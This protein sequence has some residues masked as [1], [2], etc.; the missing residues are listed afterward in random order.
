ME[1]R[2]RAGQRGRKGI[3]PVGWNLS[4]VLIQMKVR[5]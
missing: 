1:G 5:H 4:N 2:R 3:L